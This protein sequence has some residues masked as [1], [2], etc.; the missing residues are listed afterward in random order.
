MYR[1]CASVLIGMSVVAGGR[2]EKRV[3]MERNGN[4]YH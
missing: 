4:Q 3:V 2:V 1:M